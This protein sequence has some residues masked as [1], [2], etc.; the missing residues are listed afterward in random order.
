MQI[1]TQ[2]VALLALVY[3]NGQPLI[4]KLQASSQ[5]TEQSREI[6]MERRSFSFAISNLS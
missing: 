5:A 2:A 6:Y 4:E 3:G 1:N